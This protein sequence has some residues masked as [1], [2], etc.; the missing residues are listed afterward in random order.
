MSALDVSSA[1]GNRF[2]PVDEFM[3]SA[4]LRLAARAGALGA[5]VVTR[6]TSD[7]GCKKRV[8]LPDAARAVGV[9]RIQPFNACGRLGLT[10]S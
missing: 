6:E 8:K 4:D 2:P 10:L 1:S 5:T 3:A 7:P 9:N